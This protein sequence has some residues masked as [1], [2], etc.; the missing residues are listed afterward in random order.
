MKKFELFD[1]LIQDSLQS[2][3]APS[4]YRLDCFVTSEVAHNEAI[5]LCTPAQSGSLGAY[6]GLG[7]CQ[8]YTYIAAFKPELA[9]ILDARLDNILEHLLF[10]LLLQRA[11]SPFEYL[12]LLFSRE[13]RREEDPGQDTTAELL[14]S[15]FDRAKQSKSLLIKTWVEIS[16][17]MKSRWNIASHH[18]N[19]TW[20]IYQVFFNRQLHITSV[21]E[22]CL[23]NLNH[24]PD[25]RAVI[26][27]SNSHGSNLHFLTSLERFQYVKELHNADRIIPLLGNV[28]SSE[29][30]ARVNDLLQMDTLALTN[31]YLTNMEEFL[32]ERYVIEGDKIAREPNP[33][34]LLTG[35]YG[36]MYATLLQNLSQLIT[37]QDCVLIRFF[38]PGQYRGRNISIFPWLQPH[39]TFLHTF[40]QRYQNQ[41][42]ESIFA[43]YF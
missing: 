17:E 3:V 41:L 36:K 42:P 23:Q 7:P 5:N 29:S 9:I 37:D 13:Y 31:I 15:S 22:E 43:T 1:H 8:N 35:E 27:A 24:I 34:G 18:R 25:L 26:S 38:F 12:C 14:L 28:L 4:N 20:E 2:S 21:S 33:E 19:R 10:K 40:L 6:L 11:C 32:L 30:V 39:V 16:G